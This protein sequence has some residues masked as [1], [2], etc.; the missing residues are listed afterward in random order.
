MAA[1][2]AR[3]ALTPPP[4]TPFSHSSGENSRGHQTLSIS[5]QKP[6]MQ[7]GTGA[8]LKSAFYTQC[9]CVIRCPALIA[10][11]PTNWPHTYLPQLRF[12]SLMISAVNWH[13]GVA[14]NRA[15]PP[16]RCRW[17]AAA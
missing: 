6:L 17:S 12:G 3:G 4:A 5:H 10:A 9:E 13:F 14:S 16:Q 8:V 15:Q 1:A 2:R 7:G 11:R